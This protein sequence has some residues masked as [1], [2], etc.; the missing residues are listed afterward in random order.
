MNLRL[1]IRIERPARRT[2]R[3][4]APRRIPKRRENARE[5]GDVE[6]SDTK[7]LARRLDALE[8]GREHGLEDIDRPDVLGSSV[9]VAPRERAARDHVRVEDEIA[10][11]KARTRTVDVLHHV[12]PAIP[13]PLVHGRARLVIGAAEERCLPEIALSAGKRCPAPVREACHELTAVL[14]LAEELLDD[15]QAIGGGPIGVEVERH[16]GALLEV[17]QERR[18]DGRAETSAIEQRCDPLARVGTRGVGAPSHM[19]EGVG[20]RRGCHGA[21][22]RKGWR[23]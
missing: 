17:P 23:G 15:S 7:R 13:R 12:E 6:P 10:R 19:L 9:A 8:E 1:D 21:T 18:V 16:P 3:E 22:K 11:S 14:P 4:I 2:P 20:L 5:R